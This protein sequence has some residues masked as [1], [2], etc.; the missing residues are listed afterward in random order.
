MVIWSMNQE[1]KY[2]RQYVKTNLILH[3]WGFSCSHVQMWELDH[4]EGWALKNW[5]FRTVV[6]KK[7]LESPLGCKEIKPVIPKGNQPWIFTGRTD[8]EPEAPVLWPPD[9]KSQLTGKDPDAGKDWRPMEKGTTEKEMVRWHHQLNGQE[10]E[11]TPGDGEGQG[12]LAHWSPWGCKE[13]DTTKQLN[14]T[15]QVEMTCWIK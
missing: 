13:S 1:S 14:W 15:E 9:A 8:A 2:S 6:L 7:T 5:C 3:M 12:I 11:Q 4:K 10:F